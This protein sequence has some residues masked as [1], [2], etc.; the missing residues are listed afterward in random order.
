M[1]LYQ[2]DKS[3]PAGPLTAIQG[4]DERILEKLTLLQELI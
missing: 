4:V 1:V 2:A 3:S